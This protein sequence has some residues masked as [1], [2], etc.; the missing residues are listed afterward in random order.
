MTIGSRVKRNEKKSMTFGEKK[1]NTKINTS[2]EVKSVKEAI[3]K[4]KKE[5]DVCLITTRRKE[6]NTHRSL[7]EGIIMTRVI[8]F[9]NVSYTRKESILALLKPQIV[10]S[11]IR[12]LDYHS[13]FQY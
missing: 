8:N 3:N 12:M 10:L 13:V 7:Y 1:R 9:E 4:R 2:G 5:L 11:Q 6:R